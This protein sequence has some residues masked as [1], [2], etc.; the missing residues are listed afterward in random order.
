MA[1]SALNIKVIKIKFFKKNPGN[2]NSVNIL[3]VFHFDY[4]LPFSYKPFTPAILQ[5]YCCLISFF[6]PFGPGDFWPDPDGFWLDPDDFEPD[7]N[8]FEPDPDDFELDPDGCE[9]EH[10]RSCQ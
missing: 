10:T 5:S 8:D 3:F 6:F 9:P 4:L 2:I 1:T 7:P